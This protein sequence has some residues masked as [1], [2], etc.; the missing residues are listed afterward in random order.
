[1]INPEKFT[2]SNLTEG[3]VQML[4]QSTMQPRITKYQAEVAK[5]QECTSKMA[6]ISTEIHN[7]KSEFVRI[8]S[9]SEGKSKRDVETMFDEAKNSV[10][11]TAKMIV[12][13]EKDF[14]SAI[15]FYQTLI[16]NCGSA[17]AQ[18]NAELADEDNKGKSARFD[19]NGTSVTYNLRVS[20]ARLI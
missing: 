17:I 3:Q 10:D 13:I 15:S 1:M 6:K 9:Q 8:Y 7:G 4:I 12:N 20:G 14:R 19:I 18:A 16:G 11:N 2:R 5:C